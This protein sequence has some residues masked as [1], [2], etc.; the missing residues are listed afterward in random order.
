MSSRGLGGSNRCDFNIKELGSGSVAGDLK[1]YISEKFASAPV[2]ALPD[3]PGAMCELPVNA[4]ECLLCVA[5]GARLR[6]YGVRGPMRHLDGQ[7]KLLAEFAHELG[8]AVS[9][10]LLLPA[11]E[12]EPERKGATE[13]GVEGKQELRTRSWSLV[14]GEARALGRVLHIECV[15]DHYSARVVASGSATRIL[16]ALCAVDACSF[17]CADKLGT[18][19]VYRA[20]EAQ[21]ACNARSPVPALAE[22][23][24]FFVGASIT[25]LCKTQLYA[26][27]ELLLYATALGF[28]P[29]HVRRI[30]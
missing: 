29:F 15:D 17:A 2:L 5:F 21:A 22:A 24:S 26:G 9:S 28:S 4:D 8:A 1:R 25:S 30:V 23:A 13:Q 19:S 12:H 11:G 10:L 20:P 14:V 16:H 18:L 27:A 3:A 6:L 7:V